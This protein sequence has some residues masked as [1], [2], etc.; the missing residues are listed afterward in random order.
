MWLVSATTFRTIFVLSCISHVWPT[1]GANILAIET[2]AG[3][4][5]WNF[6]SSVI[7]ALT[8]GGHSV[9]VFTPFPE[10]DRE[11]YTEVDMSSTIPVKLAMELAALKSIFV[12]T[13]DMTSAIMSIG[14]LICDR[15]HDDSRF[16]EIVARGLSA[17]F[18]A[19]LV[20]PGLWDCV[21]YLAAESGLPLI[22]A[23]PTVSTFFQ[24]ERFV[25]GD[26]SNPAVVS[27]VVSDHA[28]PRT[29]AQR[30]SNV[31]ERL[32]GAVVHAVLEQSLKTTDPKPYDSHPSVPPSLV[33]VNG[34]FVSDAS[35]PIAP[36][37][38]SVGGLHLKPAQKIPQVSDSP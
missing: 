13:W 19:I 6:V 9:T 21:T 14:R 15:L 20:E 2:V 29:F 16:K 22:F 12:N 8:N 3:K 33:F 24:S 36:N 25:H 7:G 34:H 27:T 35:K 4:S 31:M 10:G 26:L 28:V 5:H 38:I 17:E 18:D 11:N 1:Y 23:V 37:V 32:Y 30:F